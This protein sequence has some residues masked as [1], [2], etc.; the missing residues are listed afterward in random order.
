M[1]LTEE[2]A[3]VRSRGSVDSLPTMGDAESTGSEAQR[4]RTA[5]AWTRSER[6]LDGERERIHARVVTQ[7]M[8]GDG[9]DSLWRAMNV[10]EGGQGTS[11]EAKAV[12]E[13]VVTA[14][15]E[16]WQA[17]EMQ[18]PLLQGEAGWQAY[19]QELLQ[20]RRMGG[21]P[22]VEAWALKSGY[23]VKVYRETKDGAGYRKIQEYGGEKGV[24][25]GI[26]WKTTRA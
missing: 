20:G 11:P 8:E 23:R 22:E 21:P 7:S 13:K 9:M 19:V 3:S 26:L 24:R 25:V 10:I 14:V 15:E 18:E 16:R 4:T 17:R 6:A 2:E 12:R 5:C 1:S